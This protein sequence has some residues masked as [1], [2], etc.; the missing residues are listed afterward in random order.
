VLIVDEALSVGDAR[1][2][3]K[4]F[5]RLE[6]LQVRG[7]GLVLVTHS[8]DLVVRHCTRAILLERGAVISQGDPKAVVHDYLN[9]L[10]GSRSTSLRTEAP[11]D[12][13]APEPAALKPMDA[14]D[15]TRDVLAER[16]GYNHGEYRWGNGDAAILDA[17]LRQPGT[18][19]GSTVVHADVPL[20]ID[21]RVRTRRA[22]PRAIVGILLKTP[23]GIAVAGT[24][25]RDWRADAGHLALPAN[26]TVDF[27]FEFKPTVASGDYMISLGVAEDV[28]GDVAPLD[29]RYDCLCITVLGTARTHGLVDLGFVFSMT[30]GAHSQA[31]F[32]E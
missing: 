3:A 9:L 20:H 22:I 14:A 5:R 16:D 13:H 30:R 10:F 31:E 26:E 12:G 6:E 7:K 17:R 29:R 2:Q 15:A 18:P 25:S 19:D 1:F 8:A 32:A 23:D 28:E 27:R 11:D 21:V 24:N 4:C